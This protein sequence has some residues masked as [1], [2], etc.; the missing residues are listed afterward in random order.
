M[1]SIHGQLPGSFRKG[2]DTDS[3]DRTRTIGE[4]NDR[5]MNCQCQSKT[6]H[7]FV[8]WDGVGPGPLHRFLCI[9]WAGVGPMEL[10]TTVSRAILIPADGTFY[11]RK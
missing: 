3:G 4:S 5:M 10:F 2:A 8:H 9:G 7:R 11:H 1:I 6:L